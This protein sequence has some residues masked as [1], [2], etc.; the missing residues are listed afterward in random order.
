MSFISI[1][2]NYKNNQSVII[3]KSN[4][5]IPINNRKPWNIFCHD[6]NM[7]T[8]SIEVIIIRRYN[9]HSIGIFATFFKCK[10]FKTHV[11]QDCYY[12]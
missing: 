8:K 7:Y 11:I 2:H 12:E 5:K 1:S 6:C 10:T 9:N 3:C 4:F